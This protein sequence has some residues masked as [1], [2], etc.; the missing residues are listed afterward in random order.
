MS[1]RC[2]EKKGSATRGRASAKGVGGARR[3]MRTP[4]AS[5]RPPKRN[6]AHLSIEKEHP[7]CR[8]GEHIAPLWT[9]RKAPSERRFALGLAQKRETGVDLERGFGKKGVNL[10]LTSWATELT[11]GD[12]GE[13]VVDDTPKK[14]KNFHLSNTGA[15]GNLCPVRKRRRTTVTTA[16][17]EE[18]GPNWIFRRGMERGFPQFQGG[19]W[20]VRKKSGSDHPSRRE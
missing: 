16:W 6:Q 9:C 3:G 4:G 12:K 1:T 10:R 7:G 20:A 13:T 5:A 11:K 14:G 18:E 17:R 15:W 19:K 2:A 8:Q